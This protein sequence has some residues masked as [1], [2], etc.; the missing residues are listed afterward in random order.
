MHDRRVVSFSLLLAAA[1]LSWPVASHAQSFNGSVSGTVADPSGS[2]VAG[3]SLVLK[4]NGTGRRAAADVRGNGA[5]AFRNL[6]PGYYQLTTEVTGFQTY[7]R[8][9]IQVALNGD[10]RLDV[11]LSVGSQAE[12]IEVI[13]ASPMM[14][15]T[16][17]KEDG[18]APETLQ[19][20]PLMFTSGPRSSATF[21]MLMPGVTTGGTANAF[22]ARI[23]GGMQAGDEAVL[24]GAS[25]QQGTLSQ[26]G[27]VSIFQDFPYSPDMVSEIKVVSSSYDAQ[28]GSTTSGQIVATTKSGQDRFHGAVFEYL[29]NDSLNANQWGATE[30]SPLEKHNFGANLGGPTKVPGLWSN[31]VKTYFYVN[32]EA[33][34]QEGGATRPTLSIPSLKQRAGDFSDWR[35]S[36]G[37]LIPIYDPATTRVLPDGTV[38]KDPFP[39]NII[40]PSRLAPSHWATC[41]SCRPRRATARSTTTWCPARF[42]TP[43]SATATTS[44]A[45]STRTSARRTT[46]PS[47]CGTSARHQ[48][49]LAAAP[50]AGLGD[51]LQPP[52]RVGA[53][54]QLG[55]HLQLQPAQPRDVRLPE[56]QRGLRLREH[57]RDRRSAARPGRRVVQRPVADELQRRLR[58]VRVS[59]QPRVRQHHHP[60]DLRP[61]RPRHLDQG[62]PHVQGRWRV[63][64]HRRKQPRPENEQGS[65][66]FGRGPTS[67]TGIDSGNPIASFLLGAVESSPMGVR[68]ASNNYPRQKAWIFHVGDTWNA[69][70][71]LTLNLGLRW[72]YYSPSSEKYDRLGFFDPD[73]VNPSAG[74]RRAASP[75]RGTAGARRATG[76]GTP[77]RTGTGASPRAS[78]SPTRSTARPSSAR[79]GASSTTARTTPAG[80]APSASPASTPT[81]P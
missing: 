38:T 37:N 44:S 52:E 34:R 20:L 8:K 27:M 35:D 81:R 1:V 2:P 29:Q 79:V 69:T 45:A 78:A 58:H 4:N 36:N 39:G 55:P 14:Y 66:F 63:P 23:N 74:G 10:V 67:L 9:G 19:N 25:M 43:S 6:V 11:A 40:P 28:Y 21:V 42:R 26:S 77:R 41:S 56:P 3:A 50:R 15:D 57:R 5:Y 54:P 65:F 61:Q 33:Y 68:T 70:S 48:V 32:V 31:S 7:V 73:G 64:Q 75:T 13:G 16:G 46:S 49:L 17:A 12:E 60:A 72:D 24:D 53:P 30:K 76:R 71:K 80:A 59:P 18:I 62:Q 51:H 22:D 47:R